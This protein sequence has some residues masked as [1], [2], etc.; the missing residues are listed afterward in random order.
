MQVTRRATVFMDAALLS[1][2]VSG[3]STPLKLAATLFMMVLTAA[4]AQVSFPLPFT[5]VPFTF[6]PMVVLLGGAVLGPELGMLSQVLYLAAGIAGLPVFAASPDLP[7]GA[8]R[9]LGATGGYLMS[10]PFAA[11]VAGWLARRGLDRRYLTSFLAMA[12]G[13]AVVFACGVTW[14][15]LF[16]PGADGRS[17]QTALAFGFYPFV[18]VDLAKLA[19]AAAV[20]PAAWK[21]LGSDFAD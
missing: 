17:L 2:G 13:L 9:L 8:A 15:T 5:P 11:F 21:L 1:V 3:L 10:Y 7:Q 4:A 14:L 12:A 20:M 18:L 16:A 19:I 6:Q